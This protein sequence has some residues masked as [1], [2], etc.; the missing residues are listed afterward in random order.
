M[1]FQIVAFMASMSAFIW[2][3]PTDSHIP[4]DFGEDRREEGPRESDLLEVMTNAHDRG[5]IF[6][7]EES[8]YL[9]IL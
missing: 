9:R 3:I 2:V 5:A 6:N 7:N 1:L 8:D 4:W